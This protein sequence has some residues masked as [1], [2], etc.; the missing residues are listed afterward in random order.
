[1]HLLKPET[2]E[3]FNTLI[4]MSFTKELYS[5]TKDIQSLIINHKIYLVFKGLFPNSSL[6]EK[7]L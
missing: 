5:E 4:V 7:R 2:K 6:F 1:M 3:P